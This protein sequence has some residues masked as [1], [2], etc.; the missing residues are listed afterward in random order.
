MIRRDS[1]EAELDALQRV[2]ELLG[3]FDE[4]VSL[5]WLDGALCALLAGPRVPAAPEDV[6]GPLF[7]DSWSRTFADPPDQA[8][9]LAAL[10]AR[11]RVLRSQLDP[12]A[13]F[14]D[15]DVLRLGP[16]MMV[17]DDEASA[18]GL[19]LGAE[20]A[21]GFLDVVA[22]PAWSWAEAA[23]GGADGE[24]YA[25]AMAM[26]QALT[27]ADDAALAAHLAPILAHSGTGGT[28]TRD[29]LVDEACYA[30]QDLRLWW[31][32]NAPR[33][34]PRRAEAVPGRNDP[35]PCG[36]GKKFKKCN[37]AG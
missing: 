3:G 29:E 6:V 23:P 25:A 26:V 9:A 5:E 17:P 30:V 35:C 21:Q 24:A 7:G 20:W 18:E 15:P 4:R 14:D 37:G 31:I 28:L 33:T 34:A 27:L 11:W 12:E 10:A 2:C 13:L 19:R 1:T 8:Q 36:S 22:D 32:E 16:L